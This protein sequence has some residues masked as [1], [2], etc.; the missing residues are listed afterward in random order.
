MPLSA[1]V[2]KVEFD[3]SIPITSFLPETQPTCAFSAG[4]KDFK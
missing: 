1:S 3:R 2:A 4:V